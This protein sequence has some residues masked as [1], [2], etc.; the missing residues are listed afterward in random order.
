MV[1][2]LVEIAAQE[3]FEAGV[4]TVDTGMSVAATLLDAWLWRIPMPNVPRGIVG[5]ETL[6][7]Q[8]LK[9]RTRSIEISNGDSKQHVFDIV[10][11]ITVS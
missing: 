9:T 2:V 11:C 10:N 7:G 6:A 4:L 3:G 5:G 1:P 8:E